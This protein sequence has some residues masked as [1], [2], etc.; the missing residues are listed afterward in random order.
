MF[1]HKGVQFAVFGNQAGFVDTH[2]GFIDIITPVFFKKAGKDYDII[3]LSD[4]L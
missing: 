3:F 4:R 1:I 2:I